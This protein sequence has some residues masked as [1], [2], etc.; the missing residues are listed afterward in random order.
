MSKIQWWI[1]GTLNTRKNTWLGLIIW[2]RYKIQSRL[3]SQPLLS[4]IWNYT[5][6]RPRLGFNFFH[7]PVCHTFFF[8]YQH[9]WG[10]SSNFAYPRFLLSLKLFIIYI[11]SSTIKEHFISMSFDTNRHQLNWKARRAITN[12]ASI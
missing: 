9:L 8:N 7:I 4:F 10:S 1:A 2:Q 3:I 11:R 5:P 6:D 12:T